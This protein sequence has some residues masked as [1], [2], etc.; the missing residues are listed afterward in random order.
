VA[1]P[2][3]VR[4]HHLHLPHE[5]EVEEVTR[6]PSD[7]ALDESPFGARKGSWRGVLPATPHP[8]PG[9]VRNERNLRSRGVEAGGGLA[10]EKKREDSVAPFP[11]KP[12]ESTL[13]RVGVPHGVAH[14]LK[15][16]MLRFPTV[17]EDLFPL[18]LRQTIPTSDA[19]QL[20]R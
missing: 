9:I 11:G 5:H 10:G 3:R 15:R 2:R 19:L 20:V 1:T 14:R 8:L 18:F 16:N 6:P 4:T 7:P 12:S 17:E 13:G